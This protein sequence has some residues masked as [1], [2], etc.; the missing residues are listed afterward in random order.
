MSWQGLFYLGSLIPVALYLQG[1]GSSHNGGSSP[2]PSPTPPAPPPPP[3]YEAL[4][5]DT[6][7][8]S[9]LAKKCFTPALLRNTT[10]D[11]SNASSCKGHGNSTACCPIAKVCV[12]V[13]VDCDPDASGQPIDGCADGTICEPVRQNCIEPD[14]N[15]KYCKTSWPRVDCV[16]EPYTSCDELLSRCVKTNNWCLPP[17]SNNVKDTAALVV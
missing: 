4:C 15:P 8:C 7:Y 1:C 5:G 6:G 16:D 3:P 14:P 10:C 13:G 2:S 9:P 11:P 17:P 12:E